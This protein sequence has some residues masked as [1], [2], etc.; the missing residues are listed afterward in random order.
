MKKWLEIFS[1]LMRTDRLTYTHTYTYG[2]T[3]FI[4]H[5]FDSLKWIIL[6]KSQN[7][8]FLQSHN[9][10]HTPCI[11]EKVKLKSLPTFFQSSVCSGWPQNS[12]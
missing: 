9:S 1:K 10:V 7:R 4:N 6:L 8:F 2:Q 11:W 3:C 5:F 12:F